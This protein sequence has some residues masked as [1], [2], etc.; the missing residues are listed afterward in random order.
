MT[1]RATNVCPE[2]KI[3]TFNPTWARENVDRW[4]YF[5]TIWSRSTVNTEQTNIHGS[6]YLPTGYC[7]QIMPRNTILKP[8]DGLV[9]IYGTA[10]K[11]DICCNNNWTTPLASIVQLYA[12]STTLFTHR[13]DLTQ[14]W[15][16]ASFHL[17]V[18][19][20]LFMTVI[21]L[22]TAM[23]CPDFPYLY[24]VHTDIMDEAIAAGG[25]FAGIV[26]QT[27]PVHAP[28]NSGYG[29][30]LDWPGITSATIKYFM[31]RLYEPWLRRSNEY[32]YED[33]LTA[34]GSS[35]NPESVSVLCNPRGR[36]YRIRHEE[37]A[38]ETPDVN[39]TKQ[40]GAIV[41]KI[42]DD[43]WSG[44]EC[45]SQAFDD[46]NLY[47]RSSA[48][49][50]LLASILCWNALKNRFNP[51]QE[52]PIPQPRQITI[53]YANCTRFLR[54]DDMGVDKH[55][56]STALRTSLNSLWQPGSESVF[57]YDDRKETKPTWWTVLFQYGIGIL[58]SCLLL[59]IYGYFSDWFHPGQS[60]AT[61][62]VIMMIWLANGILT[63]LGLPLLST[64]ELVKICLLAPLYRVFARV[65]VTSLLGLGF[66][67]HF[68]PYY[69][70]A[71]AAIGFV[72]LGIFVAPIWGFVLVGKMLAEWGK[73][74]TL[75]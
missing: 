34:E 6:Y 53:Y 27:V 64:M 49:R 15:G 52:S 75:W 31:K 46:D 28:S 16:Y 36:K 69:H 70:G 41:T 26:A 37:E 10:R 7:F 8:F 72:P 73:C 32:G 71:I 62:C 13:P 48:V 1:M 44:Y 23:R 65:S 61:E 21:N 38:H 35:E 68:F 22:I 55:Q 60:S 19:P 51:Q 4:L 42:D 54:E 30:G 56:L 57:L 17:T 24:M 25:S 9:K 39:L 11:V 2:A 40:L 3:T 18:I 47:L 5:D 74:E 33:K 45:V 29:H 59:A 67:Y 20:Y 14:R 50:I 12:S 43:L 63:G 58:L 66:A